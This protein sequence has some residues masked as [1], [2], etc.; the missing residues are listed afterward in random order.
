M[1]MHGIDATRPFN[2]IPDR[3]FLQCS[4]FRYEIEKFYRYVIVDR[5]LILKNYFNCA[6]YIANFFPLDSFVVS[7]ERDTCRYET[8]L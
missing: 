4:F 1:Q 8:V 5:E 3:V 6:I 2:G 7:F